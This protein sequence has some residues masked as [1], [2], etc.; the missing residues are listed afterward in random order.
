MNPSESLR[1]LLVD[2]DLVLS[3]YH[4]ALL[5]EAGF[6]VQHV[7][8]PSEALGIFHAFDPDILVVDYHLPEM[9]GPELAAR[10]RETESGK[11]TAILLITADERSHI[12]A[13]AM[14]RGVTGFLKKPLDQELFPEVCRSMANNA[15]ALKDSASRLLRLV[16]EQKFHQ[17]AIDQHAIVSVADRGGTITY[18]N[19][20]FCEISGYSRDEL[21]G[22]NHRIVKSGH[23][24]P[25]FYADMW[26]TISSG[27]TWQ[28]IICNRKKNGGLYWVNSTIVP[29]LDDQGQP[30]RY[31]S[32]RTDIT[33]LKAAQQALEENTTYRRSILDTSQ[34]AI[35]SMDE[36]GTIVEFNPAAERIFGYRHDEAIHKKLSELII[37]PAQREAHEAGLRRAVARGTTPLLN[38]R[39]EMSAMRAN[40]EEFPVEIALSMQQ[41]QGRTLFTGTLRDISARRQAEEKL[42]A[43][44]Q[45][46]Q[47]ARRFLENVLD[48]VPVRLFWKD[49]NGVYQGCNR[50][51]AEDIGKNSPNEVIGHTDQELGIQQ[52]TRYRQDDAEIV[53]SG[54]PK[55]FYKEPFTK[56]DGQ[57]RWLQ[58]SKIPLRDE[59]G[60]II[61][62]LG[63]YEDIT[64]RV[65]SEK[66]LEETKERLRFAIE[67]AGDGIWDWDISSGAMLFAGHY[68][69]MLG[70]APGEI[71][72]TQASWLA[73]I[74]PEDRERVQQHLQDYLEGK[75]SEYTLEMRLQCKDG[76]YKWILCR[77]T[78]VARDAQGLALRMIGIHTDITAQ[79]NTESELV[80][81]RE[82]AEKANRTKSEFL[83]HM[84]HELRTP[85]NSII[86][87]S[88]LLLSS[89]KNPLNDKQQEQVNFILNSSRHLL[90]LINEILDL[91]RVEAGKITLAPRVF[92]LHEILP[93]CLTMAESYAQRYRVTFRHNCENDETW[94][95]ADPL[96]AKQV[97][98]NLLSNAAKFNRENGSVT[99]FCTPQPDGFLRFAVTDTGPGIPVERQGELFQVFGRL[100]AERNNI[101][102]TGIGLALCKKLMEAMGGRIGFQSV[103]NQGSTFWL[104]FPVP[105]HATAASDDSRHAT[106]D[107]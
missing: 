102:G 43:S 103:P 50:L 59:N 61:G 75:V 99:L 45:R 68:E 28:G 1:A 92:Q 14:R 106:E 105:S 66:I 46:L 97:I 86:G 18:V 7:S 47:E 21:L 78:V 80:T 71:T 64:E 12:M 83:S 101:E 37:P 93:D 51:F 24:P 6:T 70:Y 94:I 90:E 77:G 53:H 63:C 17:Q 69:Q 36:D 65:E 5:E 96:R 81:A 29:F 11:R 95:H 13:E 40:G 98:L 27:R 56:M 32:I 100:D 19:Q 34:D 35:I 84:S 104:D 60:T 39:I 38:Q 26:R 8:R 9:T 23:H 62:I 48:T 33:A 20:K 10:I 4:A 22:Q 67:G 44:N 89:Q 82:N 72:P 31:I 74:H 54:Q 88:Q 87:F 2:D 42:K 49:R 25:E 79:K 76:S 3:K 55:L 15:H 57:Q 58:T 91:A 107:L 85:L 52:A 30:W 41:Y 73:M 16:R